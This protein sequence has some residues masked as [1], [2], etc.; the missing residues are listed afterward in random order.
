MQHLRKCWLSH[1]RQT[2]EDNSP[3]QPSNIPRAGEPILPSLLSS[4]DTIAREKAPSINDDFFTEDVTSQLLSISQ[5][6]LQLHAVGQEFD[7]VESIA[8]PVLTKS[9]EILVQVKTVGLNPIDWKAPAFG[10]GLPSLPCVLGRDFVGTVVKSAASCEE[11][12]RTGSM[13][14]SFPQITVTVEKQHSKSTPLHL[15]TMCIAYQSAM[16]V[17][18]T[19]SLHLESLLSP[20]LLHSEFAL[21]DI[22][23]MHS[24]PLTC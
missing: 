16:E 12:L 5:S 15:S 24:D 7:L 19:K 10:W 23:Q 21:V 2:K 18:E 14:G 17:L 1:T 3:V 11:S 20:P 22:W 8:L 6:Q 4:L 9:H 13:V